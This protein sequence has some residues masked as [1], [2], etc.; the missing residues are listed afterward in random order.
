M[1]SRFAPGVL[2]VT[3]P[4]ASLALALLVVA[5]RGS[6]QSVRPG[7]AIDVSAAPVR[8]VIVP[9]PSGQP[10]PPAVP[11]A[12]TSTPAGAA[13]RSNPTL[14][15]SP[16]TLPPAASPAPAPTPVESVER[17]E[18]TEP[19]AEID[20]PAYVEVSCTELTSELLNEGQ[21]LD[22]IQ[23][24]LMLQTSVDRY[25]F[26]VFAKPRASTQVAH[27]RTPDSVVLQTIRHADATAAMEYAE[28]FETVGRAQLEALARTYY[29]DGDTGNARVEIVNPAEPVGDEAVLF[30]FRALRRLAPPS[31]DVAFDLKPVVHMMFFRAGRLNGQV[32]LV[33]AGGNPDPDSVFNLARGLISSGAA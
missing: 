14:G 17:G 6:D 10:A 30:V 9:D 25:T 29:P 4:A 18:P 31:A 7:P 16:T 26:R 19:T 5:C 1:H 2:R 12:P 20:L 23:R 13:T 32:T 28:S 24:T 33:F 21:M 8:G 11:P 22:P 3:R 27:L 15:M